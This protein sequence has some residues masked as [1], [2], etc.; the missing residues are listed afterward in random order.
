MAAATVRRGRGAETVTPT[1]PTRPLGPGAPSVSAIG[2]GA[3][4]LSIANR[5]AEDQA[6]RAVRAALEHGATLIDT[7]DVYCLDDADL[8]HN[9]RLI[10]SAMKAWSGTRPWRGCSPR[11]PPS[12]PSRVAGL[13]ATCV[14]RWGQ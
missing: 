11:G 1:L 10:A 6:I 8:G 3:M 9:E 7:A 12:F 5:P 13:R 4:P 2:Y 14:M